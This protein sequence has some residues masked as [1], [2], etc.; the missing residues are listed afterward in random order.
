MA[1]LLDSDVFIQAANI[2]YTFDV[3][4][5]FWDWMDEVCKDDF[6]SIDRVCA[7]LQG[8]KDAMGQWAIDRKDEPWFHK[9]DDKDTQNQFAAV[10]KKVQEGVQRQGAKDV[11]LRG[12]DPWLVAKAKVMGATVVTME[13]SAPLAVKVIKLP[14]VCKLFDVPVVNTFEVLAKKK[15]EFILKKK[16]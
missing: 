1:Y 11:F 2:Y 16:K 12:A 3:F 14:D 13:G 7:E 15:A 5:G 6:C 9:V 10:A 4:P 8:H